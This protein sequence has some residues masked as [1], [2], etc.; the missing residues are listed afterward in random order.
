MLAG[1]TLVGAAGKEVSGGGV[2]VLNDA[3]L[4]GVDAAG[5]LVG[6][7]GADAA[8]TFKRGSTVVREAGFKEFVCWRT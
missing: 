7:S 5:S 4:I 3:A 2:A 8:A 6:L 1:A